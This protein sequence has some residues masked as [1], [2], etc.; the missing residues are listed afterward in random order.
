MRAS[1]GHRV[2]WPE[3]PPDVR[4]SIE[5]ALGSSVESADNQPGGFSP[6]LAARCRLADGRRVFVK[7]VSSEQNQLSTRI[8]RREIEVAEQLPSTL[9][10]PRLLH[11][12]DDGHWVALVFEDVDGRTPAEPW[13]LDALDVVL[14][15]VL[16]LA[17]AATPS[18]VERLA[19]AVEKHRQIF[20][21]WRR[22]AGGDGSVERLPSWV[23][24]RLD[25][26][27]EL[28]AGWEEAADGDTLLH[29]DLRADNVLVTDDGQV[30]FVDWPWAC[31][32]AA[33]LDVLLML[34]S[35][36]VG[37]GPDPAEVVERYELFTDV[38]QAEV[39]ATLAA[40]T[41][42]LLRESSEPPPPG[43]P[44]LRTFQ[45]AQGEVALA[46]LRSLL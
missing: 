13:T 20:H 38:D 22:L 41:G 42:F 6:G 44:A 43:I 18:P 32:G 4:R 30:V 14:P 25:E 15:A 5:R 36:G 37:G 40:F 28:E 27:A 24:S 16:D 26:L 45:R 8:H 7:A 19:T 1:G 21:G 35:I 2:E 12:F 31:V 34:P 3:I 23:G 33:F 10:A 39:L 17:R 46:W 29:A 11:T 9:P